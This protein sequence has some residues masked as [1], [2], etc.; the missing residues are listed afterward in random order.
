MALPRIVLNERKP[1]SAIFIIWRF[2][3]YSLNRIGHDVIAI[4][5]VLE[6]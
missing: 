1:W 6:K 3:K 5:P 2:R 4:G